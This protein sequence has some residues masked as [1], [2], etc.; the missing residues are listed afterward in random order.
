[1]ASRLSDEE[2]AVVAG[3][4]ANGVG[5]LARGEKGAEWAGFL[6]AVGALMADAT[7]L[8]AERTE[9]KVLPR[10]WRR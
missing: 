9:R 5:R 10:A 8:R 7:A 1:M 2:F 6:S 4:V 3:V